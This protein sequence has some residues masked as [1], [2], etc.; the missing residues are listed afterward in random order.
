MTT[1]W[2]RVSLAYSNGNGSIGDSTELG[3]RSAP[4]SLT[5]LSGV[6]ITSGVTP[7]LKDWPQGILGSTTS[8]SLLLPVRETRGRPVRSPRKPSVL[9]KTCLETG[10]TSNSRKLYL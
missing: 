4:I 10:R 6:I 5:T 9:V 8:N 1:P 7:L 3:Q 2:P